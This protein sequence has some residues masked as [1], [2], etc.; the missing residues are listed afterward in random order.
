MAT[1]YTFMTAWVLRERYNNEQV[2]GESRHS[3]GEN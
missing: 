2:G 1:F 3:P